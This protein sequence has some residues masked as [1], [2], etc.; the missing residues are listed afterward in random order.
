MPPPVDVLISVPGPPRMRST[1]AFGMSILSWLYFAIVNDELEVEGGVF[2]GLL[3]VF[4]DVGVLL[5]VADPLLP[6][7]SSSFG[8]EQPRITNNRITAIKLIEFFIIDNYAPNLNLADRS[9]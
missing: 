4:D 8:H 1:S 9:S 3:D 5:G 6:L 7:R 2:A